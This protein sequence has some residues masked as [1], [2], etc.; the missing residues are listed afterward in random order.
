MR[1][2]FCARIC[3]QQTSNEECLDQ[4]R[5]KAKNY[6]YIPPV[7][8][9]DN[10]CWRSA[11]LNGAFAARRISSIVLII[12]IHKGTSGGGR[13]RRKSCAA[14]MRLLHRAIFIFRSFRLPGYLRGS[15]G[16]IKTWSMTKRKILE[17]SGA[18]TDMIVENGGV[19]WSAIQYSRRQRVHVLVYVRRPRTLAGLK[20]GILCCATEW[21][22]MS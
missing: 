3:I 16:G 1:A 20:R 18:K 4:R 13:H 5:N 15:F 14:S 7:P 12:C 17:V 10:T 11:S 6:L 2:A 9:S 21:D 19:D 8:I 22:G